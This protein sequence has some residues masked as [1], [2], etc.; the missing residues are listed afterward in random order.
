M[1]TLDPESIDLATLAALASGSATEF[2]L[3]QLREAGHPNIRVSHGY[4]FQYLLAGSPTVG[5]LA[6]LLR[7]TQQGASK[8]VL[9]LESLGYV[10]RTSDPEDSRIRRVAL[11]AKGRSVVD[12]GR[13]ARAKLEAAVVAKVGPQAIKAARRA[14]VALLDR[15]G[16]LDAVRTRRVRPPTE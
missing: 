6:E 12:R 1:S 5:E 2:L 7:V 9:E 8:V 3:R 15:T 13:T 16:G 11:T 4:V 14:L 10:E